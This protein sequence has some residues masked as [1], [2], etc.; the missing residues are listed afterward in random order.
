LYKL[1]GWFTVDFSFA[2]SGGESAKNAPSAS[3]AGQLIVNTKNDFISTAE[4]FDSNKSIEKVQLWTVKRFLDEA[5]NDC[6]QGTRNVFDQ[7]I[8]WDWHLV[9]HLFVPNL[10]KEEFLEY[11]ALTFEDWMDLLN[12]ATQNMIERTEDRWAEERLKK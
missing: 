11:L 10:T 2:F 4:C 6:L 1:W 3:S 12:T 7:S 9:E 5:H 8:N